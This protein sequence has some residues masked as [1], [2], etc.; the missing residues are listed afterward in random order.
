VKVLVAAIAVL[1]SLP[2]LAASVSPP[3]D[4]SVPPLAV[5]VV[6]FHAL[7]E[8]A[9][10]GSAYGGGHVTRIDEA[11]RFAVVE[12]ANPGVLEATA[13]LDERVRY[14]FLDSL[15][16]FSVT[17]TPNDARWNDAGMYGARHVNAPTAWDT[18][19][20]TTS[21]VVAVLDTGIRRTHE[22]FVGGRVLQGYDFVNS[23][24]NPN[25]DCGHGTHVAGTIG[26]TTN[27]AKGIAGLAQVNILPVK[28]L[29]PVGG[30]I[31]VQCSGSHNQIASGIRYAADQGAAV[32]SMSLGGTSGSTALQ[33]AVTYATNKGSLVIAATGND[34]PCTNCVNYP[35]KYADAVAVACTDENKNQCSFS[36]DGPE[37]DLS[38]PG[39]NIL[40]TYT[41]SDTSYT[42][43]SGTSMS[44]PHVSGVAALVKSANP[45]ISR[46]DLR[47]RL[48]STAQDRG[49]AGWDEQ[50]GW[51][52]VDAAA[53]LAGSTPP[54]PNAAPTASFTATVSGLTVSVNG[55]GSSDSD[56]TLVSYSWNWGDGTAAG[57]GVTASHTYAA[58]GTYTVTLTV[59]DDDGATGTTSKSV[60]VSSTSDPDPGTPTLSNGATTSATSGATGTWQYYKISVPSGKSKLDVVIDGPSCGLLGCS[61]DLDLYV[62]RAAKP[63]A[64]SYDC[65][66]Y[67]SGSDETC[68]F[69]NPAADW[70][71]IGVYVYSGSSVAYTV[72]A[73]YS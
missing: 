9:R 68:S 12:T 67:Q 71:Y 43:L 10:E 58:A 59:T 17:F 26:A 54:P 53:A 50:F 20:G 28:V 63:T 27:N 22:D 40:S 21:V 31:N 47:T 4:E 42:T 13:A 39:N 35:A 3:L 11:L 46:A 1:L 5:Y 66:P 7:P 65:R 60:T 29:G 34:G 62:K 45:S 2:P 8:D 69:T 70:W 72:K 64:S 24:T 38:G 33:D 57:S 56:G 48:Q 36:S 23:D 18:T 49:A 32:I 73:T 61:A 14:H 25:D 55:G 15:E 19:L 51:G 44:T 6:G 16:A 52:L 41:S 30:L 37:T